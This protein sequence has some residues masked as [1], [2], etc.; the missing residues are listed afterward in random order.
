MYNNCMKSTRGT[1]AKLA[2]GRHFRST[3]DTAFYK[4]VGVYDD[5]FTTQTFK[6]IGHGV[7]FKTLSAA[8]DYVDAVTE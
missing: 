3:I 7:A 8:F 5:C 6:V 1:N 4:G 2:D